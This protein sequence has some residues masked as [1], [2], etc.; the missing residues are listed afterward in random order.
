[1]SALATSSRVFCPRVRIDLKKK[2]SV[3]TKKR[4]KKEKKRTIR[5]SWGSKGI[6]AHEEEGVEGGAGL[7]AAA[8]LLQVLAHALRQ[9][10]EVHV[11]VVLQRHRVQ[12][13]HQLC[14]RQ[15]DRYNQ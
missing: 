12:V 1:M 5:S 2:M 6:K 15:A 8:E 11:E 10:M 4:R 14:T 3:E 13:V 9:L 7:D